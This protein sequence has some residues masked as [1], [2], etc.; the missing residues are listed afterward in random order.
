[1]KL[2]FENAPQSLLDE[3]QA[4]SAEILKSTSVT[5]VDFQ[6][7]NDTPEGRWTQLVMASKGTRLWSDRPNKLSPLYAGKLPTTDREIELIL[8]DLE[9]SQLRTNIVADYNVCYIG[10]TYVQPRNLIVIDHKKAAERQDVHL[11]EPLRDLLTAAP[12]DWWGSLGIVSSGSPDRLVAFLDGHPDV[13]PL[14]YTTGGMAKL[15]YAG[16]EFV[17]LGVPR[18]DSDYG[19][20]MRVRSNALFN[21]PIDPPRV[22][23]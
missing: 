23:R 18:P 1:M 12:F 6:Y 5:G 11:S 15:K 10:R 16:R 22:D 20:D 9:Y 4:G 17:H 14:T 2:I 7:T 8:R 19:I 21:K 13:V 3:V